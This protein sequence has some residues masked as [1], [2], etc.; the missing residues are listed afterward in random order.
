MAIELTPLPDWASELKQDIVMAVIYVRVSKDKQQ[1]RSTE[2]QEELCRAEC[3]ERGWPVHEHVFR[4]NS[5]SASRHSKKRREEFEEM[6]EILRRPGYVLVTFSDDRAHRNVETYSEIRVIC[7]EAQ[8][9]WCYNGRIYDMRD[10]QDR[11]DSANDAVR[12]E[13]YSEAIRKNVNRS[14]RQGLKQGRPHAH[15]NYGYK[16]VFDENGK[17]SKRMDDDLGRVIF[18]EPREDEAVIVR[19]MFERF[20]DGEGI[21]T[22]C[23]D[24]L[25]RGVMTRAGGAWTRASIRRILTNP[26]YAGYRTHNGKPVT[27]GAWPPLVSEDLFERVQQRIDSP[28][29]LMHVSEHRG[30]EP[31]YELSGI[32]KCGICGHPMKRVKLKANPGGLYTC[33]NPLKPKGESHASRDVRFVE[34]LV[35]EVLFTAL[36][37]GE[38]RAELVSSLS[39][40]QDTFAKRDELLQKAQAQEDYL[41]DYENQAMNPANMIS[42]KFLAELSAKLRPEIK[43]LRDRAMAIQVKAEGGHPLLELLHSPNPRE[44]WPQLP[45]RTRRKI[46]KQTFDIRIAPSG[47]GLKNAKDP[48]SI[49]IRWVDF[50]TEN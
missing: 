38:V 5:I 10:G 44:L 2:E 46:L 21:A 23:R 48:S 42:A 50:D 33:R 41:S 27:V 18:R 31:V 43:D 25:D 11:I 40:P 1:G 49:K 12:A 32:A 19:E 47:K 3:A 24:L 22:I 28:E 17:A 36:E 26:V 34:E 6:K 7:V 29:R 39:D 13:A 30:S 4:D 14:L 37:D 45:I 16:R 9:F 8:S 15:I 20:D 35:R